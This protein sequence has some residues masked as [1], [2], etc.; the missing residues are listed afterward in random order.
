M[1]HVGTDNAMSSSV[2]DGL[3]AT[4]LSEECYR[5]TE[6]ATLEETGLSESL[7]GALIGKSLLRV[8]TSTGR[9][10]AEQICL[11]F[12]ILD[13]ILQTL[14]HR[15]VVARKGSAPL[16]D[17][18]YALTEQ[19]Q[20]WAQSASDQC[21]YVGAAPVPMSDYVLATEAQSIRN[22]SPKREDLLRAFEGT[23]FDESLCDELGP[24]VNSG[25][26]LFLHGKPGNGKS[27][28]VKR[29][30]RCF[31]KPIWIPHAIVTDGQ[32]IKLYDPSFHEVNES[33]DSDI[34]KSASFDRRWIKI[35]RPTIVVG[36]ELA[37]EEL[38]IRYDPKEKVS[39]APL[40][41]KSNG[42]CLLIDD[43]GR[44]RM[45]PQQLLNRWIVPLESRVD[46]LTLPTGKKIRA[47]VEQLIIFSTNVAL[48]QVVDE[49]M[50][51]RIPY[52]IEVMNPSE[53]EFH[54][55]FEMYADEFGCSYDREAVEHLLNQHY[56]LVDRQRRR[57]HPRDLLN[58]IRNY[59]AYHDRKFEMRCEYFDHVVKSYF[60]S[61]SEERLVTSPGV[62]SCGYPND[63]PPAAIDRSASIT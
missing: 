3:L 18:T 25:A 44:Q 57:C 62:S 63:V 56:R 33:E 9:A 10:L 15:Q 38:E 58:Q 23:S 29:I 13:E 50:L 31:T 17:Y 21:S 43:M 52:K 53:H 22:E 55:L 19:G 51:R 48:E 42:G 49:T 39:D 41:M 4:I 5:P 16:N 7:V 20:V 28:L 12:G 36:E 2:K 35:R 1:E 54:Q 27:T 59:C 37:M 26:A 14:R 60:P 40:Q 32:I 11:P 30:T 34:V 8:E 24:A 46:Y 45:Q 61:I 47:P 6:P